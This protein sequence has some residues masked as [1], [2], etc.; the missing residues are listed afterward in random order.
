MAPIVQQIFQAVEKDADGYH[1]LEH[2]CTEVRERG[3][4]D[5]SFILHLRLV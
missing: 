4:L 1:R 2:L 5:L 3:R